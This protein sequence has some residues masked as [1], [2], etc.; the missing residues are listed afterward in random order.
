MYTSH[1][2]SVTDY[3]F[4]LVADK[5]YTGLYKIDIIRI[6]PLSQVLAETSR[7]YSVWIMYALL[8]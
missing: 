8:P 5:D 3:L 7:V 1:I 4:A 2:K 6:F